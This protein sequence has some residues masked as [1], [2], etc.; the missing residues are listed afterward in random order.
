MT[1]EGNAETCDKTRV[2]QSCKIRQEFHPKGEKKKIPKKN[3]KQNRKRRE[4]SGR[5]EQRAKLQP[6][7]GGG[8]PQRRSPGNSL[9][10]RDSTSKNPG[11][12]G[13]LGDAEVP[14]LPQL[15]PCGGDGPSWCP[16]GPHI[17]SAAAHGW[18]GEHCRAV[19]LTSLFAHCVVSPQA[20]PVWGLGNVPSGDLR[21]ST[22][23]IAQSLSVIFNDLFPG[24]PNKL[25]TQKLGL[26]GALGSPGAVSGGL[27]YLHLN[28]Q[29]HA[30][31]GAECD[32]GAERGWGLLG[33]RCLGA[34]GA[35]TNPVPTPSAA[36]RL[37][38][39]FVAPQTPSV[40]SGEAPFRDDV[41]PWTP[42]AASPW[43][44]SPTQRCDRRRG[45][46]E[47]RGEQWRGPARPSPGDNGTAEPELIAPREPAGPGRA[48]DAGLCH[49]GS[50]SAGEAPLSPGTER[51]RLPRGT[52]IPPGLRALLPRGAGGA[53][54]SPPAASLCPS[55]RCGALSASGSPAGAARGQTEPRSPG[56]QLPGV[57]RLRPPPAPHSPWGERSGFQGNASATSAQSPATPPGPLEGLPPIRPRAVPSPT[58]GGGGPLPRGGAAAAPGAA[59]G[60]DPS[61]H[62]TT[63]KDRAGPQEG[64]ISPGAPGAGGAPPGHLP[65]FLPSSLPP[66]LREQVRPCRGRWRGRCGARPVPAPGR[67]HPGRC[68]IKLGAP[69]RRFRVRLRSDRSAR[70]SA[71]GAPLRPRPPGT[72]RA[73]LLFFFP[74]FIPPVPP[75]AAEL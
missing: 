38:R 42:T 69:P 17:P 27:G 39:P 62:S 33:R 1:C 67:L 22:A 13:L 6:G 74:S 2:C 5:K 44:F 60:P 61:T 12:F 47:A 41:A 72:F 43:G 66:S 58:P 40:G 21:C 45:G 20:A 23:I 26:L 30:L 51:P 32:G 24:Q 3:L 29:P 64:T 37:P 59:L 8:F 25:N 34:S 73:L 7:A 35:P 31:P 18:G 49:K 36:P 50:L 52:G 16:L 9:P 53:R 48:G 54:P 68:G 4:R 15:S 56:S 46:R 57:C 55:A 70:G 65:P 71:S 14:A 19:G 63:P 75:E 28:P 10:S 11:S